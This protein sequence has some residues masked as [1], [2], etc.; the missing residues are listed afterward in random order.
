MVQGVLLMNKDKCTIKTC[1]SPP[2]DSHVGDATSTGISDEQL[3]EAD[4]GM[5]YQRC[6][7][8]AQ[9]LQMAQQLYHAASRYNL[10]QHTHL[11]IPASSD[12]L[13]NQVVSLLMALSL[14]LD[15]DSALRGMQRQQAS[16]S[17]GSS[18]RHPTT[19]HPARG[20]THGPYT[21]Y[22]PADLEESLSANINELQSVEECIERLLRELMGLGV[23]ATKLQQVFL[24]LSL[25]TQCRTSTPD[26]D[27]FVEQR[28][29]QFI[30]LSAPELLRC[31]DIAM[32]E[33]S[34][35]VSVS[36]SMLQ[37]G[38]QV[39]MRSSHP[40][41]ALIGNL[42]RRLIYLSPSRMQVQLYTYISPVTQCFTPPA[43]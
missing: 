14:R 13:Q 10:K 15:A 8:G 19:Q 39:L 2:V 29:Q 27:S 43:T 34:R 40:D 18:Y 32:N 11:G 25:A 37:L 20:K 38:I 36:R 17:E 23:D 24:V 42:Y 22:F 3:E 1:A 30:S 21:N 33:G 6:M 41:Y 9:F 12:S 7:C 5:V 16:A 31:A 26:V 4:S 35:C 28:Q